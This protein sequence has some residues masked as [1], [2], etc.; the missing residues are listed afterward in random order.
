[1]E[2]GALSAPYELVFVC[3]ARSALCGSPLKC[4]SGLKATGRA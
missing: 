4:C 1:V 3:V 2:I